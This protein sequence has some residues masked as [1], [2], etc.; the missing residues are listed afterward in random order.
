MKKYIKPAMTVKNIGCND[1]MLAGSGS[2]EMTISIQEQEITGSEG[3]GAKAAGGFTQSDLWA[4]D[5]E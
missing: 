4:D 5:E 1:T 2:Q 3:V